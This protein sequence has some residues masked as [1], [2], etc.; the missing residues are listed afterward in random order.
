MTL[1]NRRINGGLERT[2]LAWLAVCLL[3]CSPAQAE[4]PGYHGRDI[5]WSAADQRLVLYRGS[6]SGQLKVCPRVQGLVHQPFCRTFAAAV[7]SACGRHEDIQLVL[8]SGEVHRLNSALLGNQGSLEPVYRPDRPLELVEAWMP[9]K[10]CHPGKGL[11]DV[12]A[13]ASSGD[14]WH[15]NGRNWLQIAENRN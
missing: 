8:A 7:L 9:G 4:P 5:L 10:V 3:G 14:L 1:N 2:F 6:D 12:L 13:V 15:F 11:N